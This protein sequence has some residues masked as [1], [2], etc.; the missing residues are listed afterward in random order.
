MTY[1]GQKK[2]SSQGRLF[3][4]KF[5]SWK[6]FTIIHLYSNL[7]TQGRLIILFPFYFVDKHR[8]DFYEARYPV[9]NG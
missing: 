9:R 2:K 8:R 1:T 5:F 3:T 4:K 6:H 7:V